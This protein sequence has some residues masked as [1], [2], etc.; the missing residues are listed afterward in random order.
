MTPG[1]GGGAG[2]G[3]GLAPLLLTL[4]L[5]D[6]S[7]PSGLYTLSHGLEGLAQRGEV[8]AGSVGAVLHGVLRHS[9][10]PSDSTALAW[11]WRAASARGDGPDH[12]DDEVLR[13]LRSIDGRLHATR[14][15]REVRDAASRTGR[16]V[17]DLAAD[18]LGDPLVDAWHEEIRA[19][20]TPGSLSVVM[21]VVYARGGVAL[22]DAVAADLHAVA[23]SCVGA[24]LRLRLADHRSAQVLLRG[25]AGVVEEVTD[26]ALER[27]L[28]EL[29]GF[30]PLLDIASA[31][32]ERAD[33]RLFAS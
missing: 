19:R 17:A 28:D 21:G 16:Q 26:A 7:F 14:L 18:L 12:D 25:A 31:H 15:T 27:P 10:G 29:G 1:P 20:R 13:T 9:V 30:A 5:T 3:P 8:D 22:R 23:V 24:A 6:S 4:Q 32:H 33:A 11:A 2:P